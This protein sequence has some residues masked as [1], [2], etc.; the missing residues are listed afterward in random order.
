[1]W[2]DALGTVHGRAAADARIVS[3]VPSITELLFALDL[4]AQVVGRTGFCLHPR[5]AVRAVPKVGGTKDVDL[6]RLRGL[7]PTHV[8]VNVDENT[9]A[10]EQALREFVPHVIVT[11]P[12]APEDNL[13]LYGLLGG[14]FDREMQATAL[15]AALERELAACRAAAFA[16]ERVLYLCWTDPWMT[17]A[18][19]TYIAR[20]LAAVGWQ[21]P[22]PPGG[23]A[24][25]AR[26]PAI[27][28]EGEVARVDRVLLSSEPYR[29]TEVHVRELQSRFPAVR[30]QWIDAELTS[31]YGVRAIVGL[32]GLRDLRRCGEAAAAPA[33]RASDG[34]A[35]SSP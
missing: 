32:R 11:H 13:A 8:I 24:G 34:P 22:H 12:N 23:F 3:L 25:A 10:C 27:E 21:V 29:F 16:P 2:T 35:R 1:M 6:D 19:D 15:C 26:Y 7:A 20:T 30:V 17:V 4:G 18:A 5:A 28:L 31:W 33:M 9:R 14:V